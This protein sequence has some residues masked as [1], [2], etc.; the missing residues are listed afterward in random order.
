MGSATGAEGFARKVA[1]KRILGGFSENPSFARMFVAEAQ[2]CSQLVHPNIVSVFDFDRDTNGQMFLV[3]ELVEG[4]DLHALMQTGPLPLPVVAYVVSEMLRGLGF[5]HTAAGDEGSRGIVHRDVSPHNVLLSWDGAVKV[6]DFGIAKARAATNATASEFVKGKP[7][8]MSPEQV[9]GGPLDGQSDLFAVGVIL[10]ELL[11]GERLFTGATPGESI[12]KVLFA[13]IVTPRQRRPSVPE[14]LDYITMRL[15]EREPPKRYLLAEDA[16]ADL[17]AC[18]AST[19]TGRDELAHVMAARFAQ[20][21]PARVR[22]MSSVVLASSRETVRADEFAERIKRAS[23]VGGVVAALPPVTGTEATMALV[24]GDLTG[25]TDSETPTRTRLGV[26]KRAAHAWPWVALVGLIVGSA[27]AAVVMT[28]SHEPSEAAL[29]PSFDAALQQA[30]AAARLVAGSVDAAAHPVT[31]TTP[32][33]AVSVQP[34]ASIVLTAQIGTPALDHAASLTPAAEPVRGG[35]KPKR[36]SRCSPGKGAAP[37]RL[38]VFVDPPTATVFV[39]GRTMGA[40]PL[41]NVSLP[42]GCHR[43]E[44]RLGAKSKRA[45]AVIDPGKTV[46]MELTLIGP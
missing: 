17:M 15:L 28:L 19:P 5:A 24:T 32:P 42:A 29:T 1:I 9:N 38:S 40:A 23:P 33:D 10:W 14:D 41:K 16:V 20:E 37:G 36:A 34:D 3:M 7:A 39:N 30:A 46:T 8:Y 27:V 4:K 45:T 25:P 21:A 18:Q 35:A 2:I 13:P 12:G 31:T 44:A 11:T 43:V 6:S 26:V 22:R